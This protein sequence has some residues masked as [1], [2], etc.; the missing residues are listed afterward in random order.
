MSERT[1]KFIN[2]YKGIA[3]AE[4]IRTGI[5]PSFKMAQAILESG[6]GRSGL[7]TDANNFFGIKAGSSWKGPVYNA[8]T[9]EFYDGVRTNIRSD[10]RAYN[11]PQ[12]SFIDHSKLLM[13]YDRYKPLFSLDFMDYKGWARQIKE[14]GYATSL[15]YTEKI[16]KIIEDYNLTELDREAKK[17]EGSHTGDDNSSNI[18]IDI[19]ANQVAQKA[20]QIIIDKLSK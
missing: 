12:A 13:R 7:T 8:K 1:D 16:I 3:I 2:D 17:K 15:N 18:D 19:L 14:S 10:F 9:H 5:P 20:I 6:W 11:S 4:A